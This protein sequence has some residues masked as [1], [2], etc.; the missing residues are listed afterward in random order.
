VCQ[1][2]IAWCADLAVS[3][4]A[5]SERHKTVPYREAD[6]GEWGLTDY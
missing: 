2:S 6:P 1:G 5:R 3:G 4:F